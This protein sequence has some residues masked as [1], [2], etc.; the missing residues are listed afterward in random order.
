MRR[1]SCV[2]GSGKPLDVSL[3]SL[4]QTGVL[5]GSAAVALGVAG[6]VQLSVG[7]LVHGP[8]GGGLSDG[9]GEPAKPGEPRRGAPCHIFAETVDP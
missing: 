9:E 6:A 3:L 8:L 1:L 7:G 5:G 2:G 4:L